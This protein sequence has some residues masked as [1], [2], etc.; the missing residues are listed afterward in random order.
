M[1]IL[2]NFLFLLSLIFFVSACD[3]VSGLVNHSSTVIVDL[4]AV[5]KA[6]GR[7]ELMQKEIQEAEAK[8]KTQLE[9]IA[10]NIQEQV[11]VEKEKLGSKK[12]EENNAKLQQLALQAQQTFRKEQMAAEQQ[13]AQLRKQLIVAFREEV[14]LVAEPVAIEQ[15]ADMVK[16]VSDDLLWFDASIDITGEVISRMRASA[17]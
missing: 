4:N 14:K 8:L 3:Q 11:A 9:Q 6:L 16:L 13:A 7:D 5:A 12:S 10:K 17:E 1:K 15:K 2:K